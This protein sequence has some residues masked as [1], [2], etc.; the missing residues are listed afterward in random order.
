MYVT[1]RAPK[2]VYVLELFSDFF[3]ERAICRSADTIW[4]E[5]FADLPIRS[6]FHFVHS[7][8]RCV[9]HID[10]CVL[11]LYIIRIY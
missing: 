7:V 2:R 8:Y 3:L 10:N 1:E 11:H 4:I 6:G 9:E 5:L